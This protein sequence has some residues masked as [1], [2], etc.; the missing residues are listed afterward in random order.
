[1]K[2][3]ENRNF[4]E[5]HGVSSSGTTERQ[6]WGAGIRDALQ[7]SY[8]EISAKTQAQSKAYL[9]QHGVVLR[10]NK[11]TTLKCWACGTALQH[12]NSFR[13][14]RNQCTQRA[15]IA[16]AELAYTPLFA[17]K[18]GDAEVLE[19]CDRWPLCAPQPGSAWPS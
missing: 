19:P 8:Q 7:P 1:M 18:A 9:Q 15:R 16:Q 12:A 5:R 3:K 17:Q 14:G 13:C 2:H 4:K 10:V 11:K 6:N